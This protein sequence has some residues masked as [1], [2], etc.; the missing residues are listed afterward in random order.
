MDLTK[1]C[2]HS[3]LN[4]NIIYII[5]IIYPQWQHWKI[6][7]ALD[8]DLRHLDYICNPELPIYVFIYDVFKYEMDS[9]SASRYYTCINCETS[10]CQINI[11]ICIFLYMCYISLLCISP[12]PFN[13][14]FSSE[15]VSQSLIMFTI[16]VM[17]CVFSFPEN[18][19]SFHCTSLRSVYRAALWS[20]STT[21]AYHI[22]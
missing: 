1:Q 21:E 22:T 10:W 14:I 18:S 13:I 2:I 19:C 16:A 5:N 15:C 7:N 12:H 9:F 3:A 6:S 17:V 4:V 11:F 20:V 8:N